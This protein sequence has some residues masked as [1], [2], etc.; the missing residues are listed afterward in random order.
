VQGYFVA[1]P[2]PANQLLE[3]CGGYEDTQSIKKQPKVV[4]IDHSNGQ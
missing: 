4:D 1:R 2:M 3:W